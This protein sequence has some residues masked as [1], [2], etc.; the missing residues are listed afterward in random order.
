MTDYVRPLVQ[1]GPA[2][3]SGALWLA[4]GWAWF[5]HAEV[6]RRGAPAEIVAAADLPAD[7]RDRLT[8]PRA[9]LAGL[10][11]DRPRLMGILNVT[12][13][14]FSDGGMH[15]DV[16]AALDRAEVLR[17]EGA[18]LVDV[19]G[20]STRPGARE[21]PA[22]AE[23]ARVL[24]VVEALAGR[25][26]VSIDTRKA[27]VAAAAAGGGAVMINDVSGLDFDPAMAATA[28]RTGTDLCVMHAQGTPETMQDNPRY[29]DV[30][31]DVHDALAAKLARAEA[32]GIPRSRVCVDPGI[33]FG[34]TQAHN[35]ALLR[36]IG[37]FH[38]LGCAILLGAS[39][40]GFIGV[41]GRAPDPLDRAPGS[42]AV[43][44]HALMQ[45]V[46]IV[47]AHD[48]ADHAQAVRLWAAISGA[49]IP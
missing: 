24:P 49:A 9:S 12:P 17:D 18:D 2:R 31:L 10:S 33:G 13:D 22:E 39:R 36:R 3:P 6:L 45:G 29:D 11:L 19:G 16:A 21:V 20:E 46:Q 28:A 38:S 14:S 42:A 25:M 43:C 15:A 47:R 44:L 1:V 30:V 41:I 48:M 32:A 34:K 5:T 40:K 7:Q 26:P 8:A 35:L 37:L 23:A 4:G 27:R